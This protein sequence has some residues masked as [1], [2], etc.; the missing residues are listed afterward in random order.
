MA[1]VLGVVASGISIVLLAI[2]IFGSIQGIKEFSRLVRHAPKDL[3][4]IELIG[5]LV[6]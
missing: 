3:E 1:E 5:S 4:Y 6:L 2:Q